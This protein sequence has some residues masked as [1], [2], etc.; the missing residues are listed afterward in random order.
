[1]NFTVKTCSAIEEMHLAPILVA[2]ENGGRGVSRSPGFSWLGFPHTTKY[3]FILAK[4][5]VLTEIVVKEKVPTSAYTYSGKLDW[6]TTYFWQVKAIEPVPSEP[7]TIGVFTVMP[8]Q[9]QPTLPAMP[10]TLSTP[11]WIWLVIG[12]L[13]LLVIVVIVLCLVKR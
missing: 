3:E 10:V 11:L 4:D 8:Q 2:P 6:G 12:I 1:M 13:T 9:P 5:A 7:S